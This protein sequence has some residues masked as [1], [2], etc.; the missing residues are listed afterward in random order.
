MKKF[1]KI[2]LSILLLVLIGYFG[3]T[4]FKK[5]S[6]LL[7]VIHKDAESVIK[8][9]VHDITKTLV[10][11]ALSSPGYYW[12][13]TKSYKD[14]KKDDS[15]ED[16][17]I[18]VDIKPYAMAFYTIKN[19]DNTFFTT[20]NI[21][22]T[23]AFEAYIDKYAKEKSRSITSNKK[24]YKTLVL[25][26]S[27]LILAWNSEKIATALTLDVPLNKLETI[28]EDV[29]L[30][31]KLISDKNHHFIKKLSATSDHIVFVNNESLITLNFKD[32]KA[33]LEGNIYTKVSD[34]YNTN[35]KYTSWKGASLQLYFDANFNNKENK[36]SFIHRLENLSFFT[37]NN[38]EVAQLV[39]RSNGFL[40]L[41][42]KGTT[43]QKDTIVSYDYDDNFE[44]V[45]VKK[46]Q[47]K[48]VPKIA[49]NLGVN[50]NESLNT[51]LENQGAIVNNVLLSM[52][53]YTFYTEELNNKMALT[54]AK[55]KLETVETNSSSFFMLNVN[56]N[57][58]QEDISIPGANE[59]FALLD[60]F[61]IEANQ[62]KG[63]NQV[64]LEGNLLGKNDDVNIISQI[65]F[66]L[67]NKDTEENLDKESL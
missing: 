38:L 47:E 11:D 10:F 64:K 44:K 9:G 6:V 59:I 19:I 15:K 48:E 39:D 27:K 30:D 13:N 32:N 33:V 28:F 16:D 34:I 26:K 55:E 63:T 17:D 36:N 57:G 43:I 56:F 29:L 20:N 49:I 45:E 2:T 8:V 7:N 50:K 60:V 35:T 4:H 24:G 42:I 62:I 66:G 21:D 12:D 18:G 3:Y 1:L 40:S 53:Y 37:K 67:E 58:L 51:Y 22:D 31:D 14:S 5:T 61:N 52:P 54:T 46:L 41:E 23:E 65:F 25:E